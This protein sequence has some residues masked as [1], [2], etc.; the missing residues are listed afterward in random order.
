MGHS[1]GMC[2]V[3]AMIR[4]R[5]WRCVEVLCICVLEPHIISLFFF[6]FLLCVTAAALSHGASSSQ[7]LYY[8]A[9]VAQQQSHNYVVC[10][11]HLYACVDNE[12]AWV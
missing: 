2:A 7:A 4:V 9:A 11:G 3:C 10:V 1:I 5:V 12:Y 8:V 6:F